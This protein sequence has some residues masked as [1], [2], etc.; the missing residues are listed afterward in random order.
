M[1]PIWLSSVRNDLD[2]QV[3]LEPQP[4]GERRGQAVV[5]R[6]LGERLR[7]HRA[8]GALGG[9]RQRPGVQLVVGHDL[10]GEPDAQR[11]VGLDLAAGD[12][13]LLGPA[14]A[15]QPGQALRAAAAGDDA[16]QDLRLAEHGPLAG[17]AVVAGQRQ[18]A[19]AAERV[20]A[21]TAAITKRGIAG[22]GV[23]RAVDARP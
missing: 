12:A 20:A 11:L 6:P 5:D 21:D 13:Q 19:A 18:L 17:D 16:E 3:L 14:R 15:D 23:E 2:E 22:D 4:L 10:V 8:A 7:H 9:E 1:T